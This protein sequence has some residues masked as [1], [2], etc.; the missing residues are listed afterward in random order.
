MM[1]RAPSGRVTEINAIG[2]RFELPT[3][4]INRALEDGVSVEEFGRM[5]LDYIGS[6]NAE[7]SRAGATRIAL[8]S[9]ASAARPI[10]AAS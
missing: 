2:Q 4:A 9:A 1:P 5:T 7:S 10:S 6:Q 3:E 8:G